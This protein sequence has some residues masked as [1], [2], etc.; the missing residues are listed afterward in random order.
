MECQFEGN[1][2][3]TYGHNACHTV[4]IAYL[5]QVVPG[6]YAYRYLVDGQWNNAEDAEK[7]KNYDGELVSLLIVEEEEEEEK[8]GEKGDDVRGEGDI[9][10]EEK[11][12]P[13]KFDFEQKEK[14]EKLVEKDQRRAVGVN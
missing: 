10:K 7:V 2:I 13:E 9:V 6:C 5:Y 1:Q 3:P 4:C 8:G 14:G 11:T 12:E